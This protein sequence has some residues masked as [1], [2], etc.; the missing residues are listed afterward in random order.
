[1]VG[2]AYIGGMRAIEFANNPAQKG[3]A[4]AIQRLQS[5]GCSHAETRRFLESPMWTGLSPSE[6][7]AVVA[8]AA[9]CIAAATAA[10]DAQK[11]GCAA[12][13]AAAKAEWSKIRAPYWR[14]VEVEDEDGGTSMAY[15]ISGEGREAL[16]AAGFHTYEPY[17]RDGKVVR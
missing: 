14:L 1:V 16:E 4:V 2:K 10:R 12:E 17:E 5:M 9:R 11:A 3:L 13:L 15:R 6:A 8:E 7:A